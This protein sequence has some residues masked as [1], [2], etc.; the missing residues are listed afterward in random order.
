MR[1]KILVLVLVL[2]CL[3]GVSALAAGT[4][5]MGPMPSAKHTEIM[6]DIKALEDGSHKL[7]KLT[8]DQK[9]TY[10]HYGD[11][12]VIDY[13]A[14]DGCEEDGTIV[15][16][17]S[18]DACKAKALD[19]TSGLGKI[20]VAVPADAHQTIGWEYDASKANDANSN[21][22]FISYTS[23]VLDH[24]SPTCKQAGTAVVQCEF[25]DATVTYQGANE[26]KADGTKDP[27]YYAKLAKITHNVNNVGDGAGQVTK[28]ET[29]ATCT[30]YK[31]T[32]YT[33][34]DCKEVVKT[35]VDYTAGKLPHDYKDGEV[36]ETLTYNSC[37]QAGQ[38]MTTVRCVNCNATKPGAIVKYDDVAKESHSDDLAALAAK[39]YTETGKTNKNGLKY[40]T[41][42]AVDPKAAYVEIEDEIDGTYH[43]LKDGTFIIK[44]GTLTF[45][46]EP[47]TCEKDGLITIACATCNLKKEYAVK[48]LGHQK[49][50]S[51]EKPEMI[52]CTKTY[53][54]AYNCTICKGNF[55]ETIGSKPYHN[56]NVEAGYD[57][58]IQYQNNGATKV[59]FKDGKAFVNGMED[60][61]VKLATCLPYTEVYC[62]EN[63]NGWTCESTKLVEVKATAKKHSAT[64]TA[65]KDFITYTKPT[66]TATGSGTYA[67]ADCG[68]TVSATIKALG[69]EAKAWTEKTPATCAA[70][71]LA[72]A[73][74]KRCSEPMEQ[75][76]PALVHKMYRSDKL[77]VPAN[78]C[79][80]GI[81]VYICDNCDA[82]ETKDI[83]A[84][85]VVPSYIVEKDDYIDYK[86]E[87]CASAGYKTFIC[88]Q[89]KQKVTVAIPKKAHEFEKT[90]TE[91]QFKDRLKDATCCTPAYY[92][93]KCT[94][95]CG[96][97]K[98]VFV[99][100]AEGHD[101][102]T[103]QELSDLRDAVYNN[104][105]D[106]TLLVVNGTID[107]ESA[108]T[109]TLYCKE[110]YDVW[111]EKDG[112][113]KKN[114]EGQGTC[115]HSW[116]FTLPAREHKWSA[117]KLDKVTGEYYVECQWEDCKVVKETTE[118]KPEYTITLD[119]TKGTVVL[120]DKNMMPLNNAYVRISYGF[121]LSDGSYLAMTTCMPIS[122]DTVDGV[123]VG[124][125]SF[126][127]LNTSLESTGVNYMVV[128]QY[129]AMYKTI[130]ELV[131][132]N[133]GMYIE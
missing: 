102:L 29:P 20:E 92:T 105:F 130:G 113:W 43:A 54:V 88:N 98:P 118:I 115:T 40:V 64:P 18:C 131:G 112:T 59:V 94:Y 111:T 86:T 10:D 33:C 3:L 22:G 19:I 129:D 89:C 108:A 53:K 21:K 125:F 83:P 99:G 16:G 56:Y 104:D 27:T 133:Y 44:K 124:T 2:V 14:N 121:E 77:S 62:C 45:E 69:H 73:I 38:T 57:Y 51:I 122:F 116:T 37:A 91:A 7:F 76:L 84:P 8:E 50:Y 61:T 72:T 41:L 95:G 96:A 70:P 17:C 85:H 23:T 126:F 87:S 127:A 80:A 79:T 109:G 117:P 101:E 26:Y 36:V 25:C 132:N 1:N 11:Y 75:T 110:K 71:G 39:Y 107:C 15:F 52:D 13:T 123:Q 60:A 100:V 49:V 63:G 6:K 35:E 66:C 42:K 82:K 65:E 24:V 28:T 68:D 48:S 114:A 103:K 12:F 119:G 93:L 78:A 74:C 34:N 106:K 9:K 32:V 31:T 81:E 55:N 30:E 46:Y 90:L 47:M 120:K 5:Y 128:D 97:E 4:N 58:I 67:C